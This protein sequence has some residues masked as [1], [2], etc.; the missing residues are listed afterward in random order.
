M[1]QTD[2]KTVPSSIERAGATASVTKVQ[3]ALTAKRI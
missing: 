2:T 3:R 1:P